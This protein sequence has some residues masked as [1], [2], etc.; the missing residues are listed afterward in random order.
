M[1]CSLLAFASGAH[2]ET[3]VGAGAALES[4]LH[5]PGPGS[6]GVFGAWNNAILGGGVNGWYIY[7]PGDSGIHSAA[8]QAALLTPMRGFGIR[9]RFTMAGGLAWRWQVRTDSR[10][11]TRVQ[12]V[13][14]VGSLISLSEHASLGLTT[15]HFFCRARPSDVEG[16]GG[17]WAASV[18]ISRRF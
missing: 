8:V 4:G 17:A 6:A 16:P 14:S 1:T 3:L 9:L 13:V 7:A 2:A 11:N 5:G 15:S 10:I 18:V 12:P